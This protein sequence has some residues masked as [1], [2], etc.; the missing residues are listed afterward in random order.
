MNAPIGISV[1]ARHV[2]FENTVEALKKNALACSS[3]LHIFSDAP[4]EGDEEKVS[5]LRAYAKGIT[6]FKSVLLHERQQNNRLMNSRGGLEFLL[7][8]DGKAIFLEEDILTA[9]GFLNFMNF[10]LEEFEKDKRVTTITGYAPPIRIPYDYS[11]DVY[12]LNRFNGWGCGFW[13][14]K[15]AQISKRIEVVSYLE[16]A[17]SAECQ[18]RLADCGSDFI[19]MLKKEID[20]E[21]NALDVRITFWQVLSNW[22]TVYPRKSL[23]QNIGHDGTGE[24]CGRSNRFLHEELWDK[25]CAYNLQQAPATDARIASL[26]K[27]FRRRGLLGRISDHLRSMGAGAVIDHLR[28]KL[29]H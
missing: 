16:V 4:R 9:P 10:M 20:G 19:P 18:R 2:H 5:Q 1:Y 25:K 8:N 12:F 6:G 29:P 14:D 24:L 23:V 26:F 7:E 11:D 3:D 13:S 27:T 17:N 15:Y 28:K 22:Y 21:I